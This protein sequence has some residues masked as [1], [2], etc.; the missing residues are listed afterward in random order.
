MKQ[1]ICKKCQQSFTWDDLGLDDD[2]CQGCWDDIC[3]QSWWEMNDTLAAIQDEGFNFFG[4]D[5]E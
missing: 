4:D 2:Y 5:E 1:H 3:S